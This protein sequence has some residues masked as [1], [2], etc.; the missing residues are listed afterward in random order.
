[1]LVRAQICVELHFFASLHHAYTTVA[2]F[3][4]HQDLRTSI[5]NRS[6]IDMP[7]S[8]CHKFRHFEVCSIL[9]MAF[10]T[11]SATQRMVVC[12]F[13]FSRVNFFI[14]GNETI[15]LYCQTHAM[16]FVLPGCNLPTMLE[17]HLHRVCN[18]AV[19]LSTTRDL[20]SKFLLSISSLSVILIPPCR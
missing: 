5:T 20:T 16:L 9:C 7:L 14:V 3:Y 1:M 17:K 15:L 10:P 6:M 11:R 8:S 18:I 4:P 12:F 2:T 13:L 19:C